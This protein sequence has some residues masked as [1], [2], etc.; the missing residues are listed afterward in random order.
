V[1]AA[2]AAIVAGWIVDSTWPGHDQARLAAEEAAYRHL[3]PLLIADDARPDTFGRWGSIDLPESLW[4][5]GV[6][7]FLESVLGPSTNPVPANF[8]ELAEEIRTRWALPQSA[9]V[10]PA[11]RQ[12]LRPRIDRLLLDTPVHRRPLPTP[13][14]SAWDNAIG[15]VA[16]P[17]RMPEPVGTTEPVGVSEPIIAVAADPTARPISS[18]PSGLVNVEDVPASDISSPRF[19]RYASLVRA[20]PRDVP[21]GWAAN[22]VTE[23]WRNEPTELAKLAEQILALT[24]AALHDSQLLDRL[25]VETYLGAGRRLLAAYRGD[26]GVDPIL[27]LHDQ[28][29]DQPLLDAIRGRHATNEL[30]KQIATAMRMVQGTGLHH[31]AQFIDSCQDRL[32]ALILL[33]DP[34]ADSMGRDLSRMSTK[35][36]LRLDVTFYSLP[37][38]EVW[39]QLSKEFRT[40]APLPSTR[41]DY[42]HALALLYVRSVLKSADDPALDW[43]QG[44]SGAMGLPFSKRLVHV[45]SW[46]PLDGKFLEEVR[47]QARL[48][49]VIP[50]LAGSDQRDTLFYTCLREGSQLV[51]EA[52]ALFKRR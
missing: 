44:S 11:M 51:A 15:A 45:L 37:F 34:A 50:E 20:A 10:H 43:L 40:R 1:T 41:I 42:H 31:R 36:A 22:Q 52:E 16:E 6:A 38:D 35:A 4:R 39:A 19:S 26:P 2:R 9:R 18:G 17:T 25:L 3:L 46:A 48:L 7:R 28:F 27:E 14:R 47:S 23:L 5:N 13:R 29:A 12:W 24:P 33:M 21:A 32:A 8:T 49:V 30:T